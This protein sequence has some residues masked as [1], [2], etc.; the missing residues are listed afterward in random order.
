[1]RRPHRHRPGRFRRDPATVSLWLP[2]GGDDL[3]PRAPLVVDT[4]ADVAILG[5]GLTGL[6]TA[7]H[8]LRRQPGL[9]VVVLE[10]EV[11]G[12]GASGRNG[13][14]CSAGF[15]LSPDRVAHRWG[16]DVAAQLHRA[17]AASVDAVGRLAGEEG[18]DCGFAKGGVLRVARGAGQVPVLERALA[19]ASALGIA[20]GRRLLDAA[21]LARRVRIAGAA[22]ALYS[23]DCAVLH[24]GRLVRGLAR[25]V[26]RRGGVIHEGS[27]V[28]EVVPGPGPRLVTERALVRAGHVV[29]AGEAYLTR[30]GPWHRQLLPVYSL[31]VATEPLDADRWDEIGW[32]GREAI[33]STRLSVDYAQRTADGRI[34]FGGRG[35]PY[36]LGS[37]IADRYDQHAP[38]HAMLRR[39]VLDWFPQLAGVRFTHAW[40]GP[41]GVSR[42]WTPAVTLDRRTGIA[43]SCG[44]AGQGVAMAQLGGQILADLITAT[45]SELRSLP[46]VGHRSP[47]WELEPLR[48]MG[49]RYAQW[50][51]GQADRRAERRGRPPSG[52]TL[53]ERLAAH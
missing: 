31:M 14:W 50:G 48:W 9:R 42:D 53:A 23:P 41:L 51:L 21:E 46:M 26:E 38:T 18:I 8:L 44:Y 6:W 20:D 12:F 3:E 11:A 36:H 5:A 27:P 47:D 30:L 52:R 24:P 34:A 13:G 39:L 19:T 22:A 4:Q 10:A 33:A 1:M 45:D 28:V 7:L 35:A 25:A 40:G 29:L 2:D 43:S 49:V 17:L 32:S 37:R 15:A 16:R